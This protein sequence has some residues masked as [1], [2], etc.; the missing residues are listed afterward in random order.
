MSMSIRWRL[1]LWNALGVAVVLTGFAGLVY[2]LAARAVYHQAD[3]TADAGF[4]LVR[5][6]PRIATDTDR[7]A[8]YWVREFD[9]HMGVLAAVYRPDG[10]PIASHPGVTSRE[11]VAPRAEGRRAEADPDGYRWWVSAE[12]VRAGDREVRVVLFVPLRDQE[13]DLAVLTRAVLL[14]IPVGLVASAGLAYVLA[15]AALAPVDAFRRAADRITA[16]RLHE[17][18]PAPNPEDELGKLA[19]TV[20]AMIGRLERSFA[21]VKRFT[22]DASHELRTPLTALRTEAEVA[23]GGSP[24][25]DEFRSLVESTLEEC[26]RMTRLTDQLLALA[27]EDAGVAPPEPEPVDIGQLVSGV[28]DTLRP[29]AEVKGV[30]FAAEAQAAGIVVHGNAVRLRQVTVNLIDNAIKYTPAGGSVRVV[31][32]RS[33]DRAHLT[34][35]DTGIGIPPEHL[36]RV[37]ERFYRVD[38]ARSREMGGTGLGLSIARSIVAAHGGS[39]DLTS[40]AGAGTTAAVTLPLAPPPGPS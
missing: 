31:V 34:I 33:G 1:T 14:A 15:R 6:D 39:I 17:R 28:A 25:A 2:L 32:G 3:R 18:L 40:R 8:A 12:T 23:L 37:F 26:G 35:A 11:A 38:K 27:R 13:T 24:T 19:A 36:P 9:E 30:T 5:T 7:R 20:N 22:A 16:D 29:L 21:E 10:S 4:R